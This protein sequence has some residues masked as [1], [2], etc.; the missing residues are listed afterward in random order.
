MFLSG[1]SVK[2]IPGLIEILYGKYIMLLWIKMLITSENLSIS[3]H[4][5]LNIGSGSWT[6][7][8][9]WV[10]DVNEVH[11]LKRNSS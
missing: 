1:Y 7:M 10:T 3:I 2:R 11:I 4:T 5:I 9:T 6:Q 8:Q